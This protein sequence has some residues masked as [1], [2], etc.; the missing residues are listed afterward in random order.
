MSENF[1]YK[2]LPLYSDS[3][4]SYSTV[5]DGKTY[6]IRI[7]FVQKTNSW[8]MS[9][10]NE[11]KAPVVSGIR[12]IPSFPLLQEHSLSEL[13]GIF[14]LISKSDNTSEEYLTKSRYLN[15]YYELYYIS[16]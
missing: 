3:D 2:Q 11:S 1:K 10:F 6:I 5:L 15:Q 9:L 12:L 14:L 16:E 4:Y 7:Y 13:S 8:Y